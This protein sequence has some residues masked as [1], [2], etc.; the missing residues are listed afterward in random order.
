MEVLP[1]AINTVVVAAV[2]LMLGWLG[3]GR[4]D[5]LEARIDRLEQ[6]L[7]G[8]IDRFQGRIDGRIDQLEERMDARFDSVRSDL[9]R[10]ALAVGVRPEA[11]GG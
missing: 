9:T 1:T 7:D 4:I 11:G 5:R 8:R 6:R 2:G 10:I 3:K